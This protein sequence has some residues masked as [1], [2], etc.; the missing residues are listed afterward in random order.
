MHV[1]GLYVQNLAKAIGDTQLHALVEL[2]KKKMIWCLNIG[3]SYEISM[4]GWRYF[5]ASLH[6]TNVTHL[7]VSEHTIPI[8]LKNEMR[9]HIRDNRSKH[10]LHRAF[11]N[12]SVI[13]RCT[14][15]WW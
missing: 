8:D 13:E 5:C 7:Y 6:K 1:Q 4:D 11:K 9:D 12:L 2:L 3:E 14:H 15:M 10:N